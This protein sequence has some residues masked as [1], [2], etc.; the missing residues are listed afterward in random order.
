MK[1]GESSRGFV[2]GLQNGK[3]MQTPKLGEFCEMAVN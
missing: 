3:R 2:M 1:S